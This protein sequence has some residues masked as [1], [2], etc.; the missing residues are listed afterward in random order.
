MGLQQEEDKDRGQ[1][2]YMDPGDLDAGDD[3]EGD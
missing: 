1:P 2:S 3:E